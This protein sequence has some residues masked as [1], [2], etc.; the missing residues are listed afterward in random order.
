MSEQRTRR[1]GRPWRRVRGRVL[2]ESD[3]CH[4][5]GQPGADSVDHIIAV[6]VRPDLE[7]VRSN[8][9]PAHYDVPP[10]CNR[11]KGDRAMPL[12]IIRRSSS[13]RRPNL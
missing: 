7:L 4:I 12:D 11:R 6:S 2:A 5:C 1:G 10:Y 8:L 9:A 3:V 13:L